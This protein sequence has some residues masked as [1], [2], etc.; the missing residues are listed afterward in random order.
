[1]RGKSEVVGYIIRRIGQ[2]ILFIILVSIG[3]FSMV[4]LTP[5]DPAQIMAGVTATPEAVERIREEM[6]LDKPFWV[7]YGIWA[8]RALQGDLGLSAETK[9][10][11][12]KE[13]RKRFAATMELTFVAMIFASIVGILAGI[14][15]AV[16]RNSF[17]D[18]A[19]MFVAVFGLSVPVFWLG[20]LLLLVFGLFIPVFPLGGRVPGSL[21]IG[22]ITGFYTIDTLMRGDFESFMIVI[23]YLFLPAIT[24]GT[25]PAALIARMTRSGMLEVLQED[26]IRTARAK[27]LSE[28]SIIFKHA[29]RNALLPIITVIGLN[30]AILLAGAVLTETIFSWPG[31]ARYIVRAVSVRDYP[32]VQGG[33]LVIAVMVLGVNTLIDILY[34]IIDPRIAY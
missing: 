13:L 22:S 31:M 17:L 18:Y 30:F 2:G 7:Q 14:I 24:L 9:T 8:K 5:G 28:R 16:Y 23:K 32:V 10:Q 34:C 1:V 12:S 21:D 15:A 26:Y 25:I 19:S 27:G 29:L 4:R 3:I 33:I 6:G 11:V 20:L